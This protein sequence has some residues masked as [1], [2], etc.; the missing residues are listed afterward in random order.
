[1]IE[2]IAGDAKRFAFAGVVNTAL[3]SAVYILALTILNPTAAYAVAWV[4]GIIF[5]VLVYPH[6]V[7]IGGSTRAKARSHLAF[8]T[9][10]IFGLGVLVLHL[11]VYMT[12]MPLLAFALTV[13]VT[14]IANFCVGRAILRYKR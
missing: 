6:R 2:G 14:T 11:L 10:G 5:V 12:S 3:T 7:F 4:L 8:S 13:I 9:I 1:M